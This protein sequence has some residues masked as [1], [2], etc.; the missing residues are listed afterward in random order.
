MKKT[1]LYCFLFLSM[2][3]AIVVM[4]M[5]HRG[6]TFEGK[7]IAVWFNTVKIGQ[8]SPS[9]AAFQKMGGA[10][11]PVLQQGLKSEDMNDR[12]KGAWVLGQLGPVASNAIPDLIQSLDDP[13]DVCVIYSIK[14]LEHILP[15]RVEAIPKLLAKLGDTNLGVSNCAADLLDRIERERKAANLPAYGDRSEYDMAFAHSTSQRVRL[16]GL[17][18]LMRLSPSDDRVVP[19]FKVLANDTNVTVREQAALFLKK[20]HIVASDTAS[21]AQMLPQ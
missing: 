9:L 5:L 14:A 10:S 7:A 3:V 19:A 8:P 2:P 1:L 13:K 18:R 6:P 4:A 21:P 17:Q 11:V 16:A 15:A 12:L 20:Q